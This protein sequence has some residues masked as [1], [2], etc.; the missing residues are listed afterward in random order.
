L[1]ED[2]TAVGVPEIDPFE[3]ENDRP[4]GRA[5]EIDHDVTF[6]PL[7]DGITVVIATPFTNVIELGL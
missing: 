1:V 7:E 6:P 5:G 2:A 4:A 3:V